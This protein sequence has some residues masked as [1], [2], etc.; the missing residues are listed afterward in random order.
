[1][2]QNTFKGLAFYSKA[3]SMLFKH[4]L[5]MYF[6]APTIISIGIVFGAFKTRSRFVDPFREWIG[7]VYPDSWPFSETID[8][9]LSAIGGGLGELLVWFILILLMKH[10]VMVLASPFMSLLSER[11]DQIVTGNKFGGF[12]LGKFFS[13]LLRGLRVALRLLTR[14][15]FWTFVIFILSF[16]IPP[17]TVVLLFLVQAYYGGAANFDFTLERYYN[18]K[19]SIRFMKRNKGAA[20]GNGIPFIALLMT[21]FG[22]LIALPLATIAGTLHTLELL[23]KE[24]AYF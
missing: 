24:E 5:W 23:E 20:L 11:V 14:E 19:G 21:V 8:K 13:D 18:Y 22:F 10:V 7:Q 1:M 9:V 3:V 2:I 17:V 15:L 4:N 16:F 6:L 12:Q